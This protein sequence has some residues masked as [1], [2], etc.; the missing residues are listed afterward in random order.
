VA[1]SE[2]G[3]E[4][5]PPSPRG[6]DW[7]KCQYR[8]EG[9]ER[10]SERYPS[11][12]VCGWETAPPFIG[13]GGSSLHACRTI[14]LRVEVWRAVLGADG[15]PGE[16][17]SYWGVVVRHVLVQERLRGW[18]CSGWLTGRRSGM[19][20]GCCW[21]GPVHGTVVAVGNVLSP[22]VPT[23]SGCRHSV[24]RGAAVAGMVAQG[25]QR[26]GWPIPPA[27]CHGVALR[28]HRK[29]IRGCRWLPSSARRVS[30]TRV[31]GTVSRSWQRPCRT[32]LHSGGDGFPL[33]SWRNS[34]GA[35][36]PGVSESWCASCGVRA[37][38]ARTRGQERGQR[39]CGCPRARRTPPEGVLSPR[40]RRTS[41]EGRG[42]DLE[43]GGPRP[44][45]RKRPR[46][47]R[48]SPEGASIPQA[49]RTSL[50][51]H[52]LC[53]PGGLR[54]PPGS[55]LCCACVLGAR[56]DSWFTFFQVLSGFPPVI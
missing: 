48:T 34:T 52:P 54:G 51:G 49:R 39:A 27:W 7:G 17:R 19:I 4:A 43:R 1:T 21:R 50:E 47:R 2:A 10:V 35:W 9:G 18:R 40:A 44:R 15:R 25:R 42:W 28:Q 41:L 5:W 30:C 45:G 55:R 36:F 16:S 38:N 56:V 8:G 31:G 3:E 12:R 46:A 32:V 22:R 29:D 23:A 11:S 14:S 20:R 33:G 53:C 37:L 24:Q 13:Q 6:V 26:R